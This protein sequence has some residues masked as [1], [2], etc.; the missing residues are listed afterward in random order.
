M[1]VDILH[2]VIA[3]SLKQ[4]PGLSEFA[5][6]CDALPVSATPAYDMVIADFDVNSSSGWG[7]EQ[8]HHT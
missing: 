7:N 4:L 6:V 2:E 3:S 1:L 8:I 5:G